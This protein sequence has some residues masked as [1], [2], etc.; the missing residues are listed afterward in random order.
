[1]STDGEIGCRAALVSPTGSRS[2]G[3]YRAVFFDAGSTLIEA[4]LNRTDRFLHFAEDWGL[5]VSADAARQAHER[6]WKAHF[7]NGFSEGT[8]AADAARWIGFYRELLA[9]LHVADHGDAVAARLASACD[10]RYWMAPY[11]DSAAVL[12]ELRGRIKLGLLSNA[13]PSLR[14]V[15]TDLGLATY[16][17][18]MTISG[19]VGVRKPDP[20]IYRV[21]LDSLGVDARESLFVD[22][23]EENLVAAQQVGMDCLL[24]DRRDV[25][26]LTAFERVSEL[27]GVVRRLRLSDAQRRA[28]AAVGGVGEGED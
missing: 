6:L 10:Y 8:P 28:V 3:P 27:W 2:Q 7:A 23:L 4:R 20:A 11:P 25:R 12:A 14:Q 19:E 13:P 16:F 1:L 24:M 26:P 17:D 5:P 9:D 21:A 22:D 15:M 18:E